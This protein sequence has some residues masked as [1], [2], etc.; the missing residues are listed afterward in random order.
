MHT[1]SSRKITNNNTEFSLKENNEILEGAENQI[2]EINFEN[3][4][5]LGQTNI[6]LG[7]ANVELDYINDADQD[8]NPI[9][10]LRKLKLKYWNR[11]II[12]SLNINSIRNKFDMLSDAIKNKLD[13]LVV[14]ETKL[15]NS[16]PDA[17]FKIRGFTGPYHLDRNCHGGGVMI[18]VTEKI[19]SRELRKFKA[20]NNFE[21]I[22]VE[23]NLRSHKL[24]L[25]GGYRS[26]HETLGM[27][28]EDFLHQLSLGLDSYSE[29]DKFLIAGD[30]N[31]L[32]SDFALEDFLVQNDGRCLVKEPTC[33]KNAESPTIIDH[34][35]T[36][37]PR[38]FQNTA[39]YNI[40]LSDFHLLI[41]T[42][43]KVGIPKQ[44]PKT[45]TYRSFSRFNEKRFHEELRNE[46]NK[47]TCNSCSNFE[48][49]FLEV[50][51]KHAPSRT[52]K[53][54]ANDKPFVTQELRKA[55]MKTSRLERGYCRAPS[56]ENKLKYTKQK[57]LYKKALQK[58]KEK[59]HTKSRSCKVGRE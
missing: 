2:S 50:L 19:S 24:L 6:D 25:F 35:I 44:E 29:Y 43:L 4:E 37:S 32:E 15:D 22:F 38:L 39:A 28:K 59:I 40:G 9:E 26:D 23:L 49:I 56:N 46:L 54:R 45:V 55:M 17:Q 18:Y 10:K 53:V 21:G 42:V 8:T 51:D 58:R 52:R 41:A 14:L 12:G 1:I 11:L 13:V 57:K 27:S 34:F 5:E 3:I 16:F 7:S 48:K 36:N 20:G 33:F 31:M 30:L 47:D